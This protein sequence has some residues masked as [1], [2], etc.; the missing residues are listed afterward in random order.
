MTVSQRMMQRSAVGR[1]LLLS[2]VAVLAFMSGTVFGAFARDSLSLGANLRQ[3]APRAML[4]A[5]ATASSPW[6][7][8]RCDGCPGVSEVVRY[9]T[10]ATPS[11]GPW[12]LYQCDGCTDAAGASHY[13]GR[14]RAAK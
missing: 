14:A 12:E 6:E 3:A 5:G 4:S 2:S 9:F 13:Y 7:L 1:W 10:G 11:Q 8:Y